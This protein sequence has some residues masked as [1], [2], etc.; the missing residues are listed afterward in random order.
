MTVNQYLYQ[1]PSSSSVQVGRL[2]PSIKQ[3]DTSSQSSS[4]APNTNE[5]QQKA[6][7]F[8]ASQTSEVTPTVSEDTQLLDIYA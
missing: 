8:A 3:E 4:S 7:A 1:S 2:D 5:T 6:E